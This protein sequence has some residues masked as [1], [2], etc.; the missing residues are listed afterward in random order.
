MYQKAELCTQ[1]AHI[2]LQEPVAGV[3]QDEP[4]HALG[5]ANRNDEGDE[6]TPVVRGEREACQPQRVANG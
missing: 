2:G 5:R 4:L 6:P 1:H 3:E